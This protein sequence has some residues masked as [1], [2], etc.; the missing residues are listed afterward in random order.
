MIVT[1]SFFSR[2][3]TLPVDILLNRGKGRF[4]LATSTVFQPRPIRTQLAR[5]LVVADFNGD[6]RPD[7]FIADHGTSTELPDDPRHG[8]QN[9]LVLSNESGQLVDATGNLPQHSDFSHS[10]TAGDVDGN[11]TVDVFVANLN[12]C[13]DR[14][15]PEILLN[16]GTGRFREAFDR[17]PDVPRDQYG[18]FVYT[19][20]ELTDVNGD[21]SLDL[22]LGAMENR[23]HSV[24]L[25]NDGRG[26]FH[27]LAD[28][29]PKLY[30]PRAEV[31]DIAP[32][33][34]NG[35]GATDLIS[36]ET[37]TDPYYIGT[38]IQ[39]LINDGR[40]RFRDETS[41]RLPSQPNAQSWPNRVLVEDFNDDAKP[42]FAIQYAQPGKVPE[43]DPTPFYLNRGDGSFTRIPGAAQ[44]APPDQRG[45]VGFV[46]GAGP[47]AMI[48]VATREGT[49]ASYFVS[50]QL[51]KLSA[52]TRVTATRT[53]QGGVRIRWRAV[54]GASRYEVWRS[55]TAQ[56]RRSQISTAPATTV[57]DRT[58]VRGRSYSYVVRA[59]APGQKGPF[60]TAATSR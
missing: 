57:V 41:T 58:A 33:D 51:V 43:P 40:G 15:Q 21:R 38:R 53:P 29:P 12:C 18:N 59:I 47:H 10:A 30:G 39:V 46:N 60:S 49:I 56:G 1:Q 16:D 19:T 13:G 55:T 2:D 27:Y 54:D 26:T 22:V 35:D 7:L 20:S 28:L 36:V 6:R 48:S 31:L 32:V 50:S 24:V 14:T 17:V 34:L 9:Q 5:K 23:A 42:D 44:G 3:E 8:Y 4:V 11:G 25:L 52:P 45:P 37:Q